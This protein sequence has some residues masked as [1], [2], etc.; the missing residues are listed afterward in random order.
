MKAGMIITGSGAVLV[1]TTYDALDD[2]ELI[3][4]LRQKGIDKFIGYELPVELC[5]SRYGAHYTAI[6]NDVKQT[7]DLRVLDYNGYHVFT[8]FS[9]SEMGE[10]VYHEAEMTTV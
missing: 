1:L 7:D 5:K 8:N 10:A 6:V 4:K 9:F 2:P 3:V